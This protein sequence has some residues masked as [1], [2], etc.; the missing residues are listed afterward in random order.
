MKFTLTGSTIT[1]EREKGDPGLHRGGYTP[2]GWALESVAL[3][4]V[5]RWLAKTHGV[6]L[7]RTTVG[8]D[9]LAG[10]A[11]HLVDDNLPILRQPIKT[12]GKGG[13]WDVHIINANS[14]V[15]SVED[16]WQ[17]RPPRPLVFHIFKASDDAQG[18]EP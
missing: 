4:W 16:N 5:M 12:Y 7:V 11:H 17:A 8:K 2:D 6:K 14:A 1:V 10:R 18:A 13:P 3:G 9:C 15:Q